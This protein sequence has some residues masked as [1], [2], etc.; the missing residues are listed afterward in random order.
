[1]PLH[2]EWRDI[3]SIIKI[4]NDIGDMPGLNHMF[5][6]TGGGQ[7]VESA[8][9]AKEEGC[10]C[11]VAG[12]CNYILKP[13]KLELENYGE[14]DHR[15][16]YFRLQLEEIE[17][18]SDTIYEDCRELL[19]EDES[20]DLLIQASNAKGK[21]PTHIADYI[22]CHR[23][24]YGLLEVLAQRNLGETLLKRIKIYAEEIE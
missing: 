8:E 14:N 23:K 17:P 10:I 18:I 15:W 6:P 21:L 13:Y 11:L 2:T 5:L 16:S 4:L 20:N 19:T 12:G 9:Y 3:D 22:A 7:D 24:A 1:V